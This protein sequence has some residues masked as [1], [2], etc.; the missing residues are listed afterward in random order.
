MEACRDLD[1]VGKAT[2]TI[3]LSI[4]TMSRLKQSTTSTNQRLGVRRG[5]WISG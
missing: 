5:S 1:R 2:L 3:V 4:T